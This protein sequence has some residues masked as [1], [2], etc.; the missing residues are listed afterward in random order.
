M[1][2]IFEAE[3]ALPADADL[4]DLP[5]EIFSL[6]ITIDA[7][8]PVLNSNVIRKL[9]KNIG[10][11]ARPA[12]RLRQSTTAAQATPRGKGRMA[13]VE[14][15]ILA[16]LLKT[17]QRSVRAGEDIDPF[18]FAHPGRPIGV[19]VSPSKK[20]PKKQGRG[21]K[22]ESHSKGS[23]NEED[24]DVHAELDGLADLTEAE[25]DRLSKALEVARE[26]IVAADCCIAL[27]GSDRL[28]KQ[29]GYS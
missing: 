10:H 4:G 16:R 23:D 9:T 18:H 21:K 2:E 25:F 13:A 24:E 11:I 20:S 8:R 5:S 1:E 19:H 29:V 7:S 3:D 22:H 28:Q 14:T 6:A 17:L 27:L 12:K 26:S 15:P